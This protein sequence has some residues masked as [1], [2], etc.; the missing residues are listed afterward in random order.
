VSQDSLDY[1]RDYRVSEA[2]RGI[3]RA[4]NDAVDSISLIVAAGACGCR[5]QDLSDA[6]SGRANRYVRIEWVLAIADASPLD[7]KLCI[8]DALIG[9]LG[10]RAEPRKPLTP[11]EKLA[12]LE[13]R[14]TAKFGAAGVEL[15]DELRK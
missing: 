3:L 9:W 1:G 13:Q 6:L 14:V 11:A 15:L 7:F 10:F 8:T 4:L 5:T 12:R 2:Q